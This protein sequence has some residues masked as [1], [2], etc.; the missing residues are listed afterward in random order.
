MFKNI[1]DFF[2]LGHGSSGR[3]SSSKHKVLSLNPSIAKTKQTTTKKSIEVLE[4]SSF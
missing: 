1:E 3:V 2:G 4:M